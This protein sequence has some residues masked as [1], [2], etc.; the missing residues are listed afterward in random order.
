MGATY[1]GTQINESPT[2]VLPAGADITGLQCS[3]LAISG[4]KLVRPSKGAN[5]IGIALRTM[6]D[7]VKAGDD[8]TVQIKDIGKWVAG[9]AIAVGDELTTNANGQAVKAAEGDFVTAVALTAAG[10]AGTLVQMQIIKAGI[11]PATT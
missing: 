1:F 11:K 6:D 9:E 10:E 8:V 5:V 3:A 4:G 7:S 2:I